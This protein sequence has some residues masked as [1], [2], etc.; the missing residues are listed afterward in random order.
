MLEQITPVVLTFNEGPNIGR[1]LE[2][3]AWAH[4][5]VVLD[6]HST[7]NT[8]EIVNGFDNAQAY[9]RRFDN[10]ATQWQFALE[11]TG[12]DTDWVLCMD[13]DWVMGTALE[14]EIAALGPDENLCGYAIPFRYLVYGEPLR[15]SLYPPVTALFRR[16]HGR[17]VQ[18][19]HTQRVQVDGG[20]NPLSSTL[21]HDDRKSLSRWLWAQGNYARLEA[22]AQAGTAFNNLSLRGRLRR[23][24][25]VMPILMPCHFLLMRGGLLDGRTGVFYALQRMIFEALLALEIV[26]Q[27]WSQASEDPRRDQRIE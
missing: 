6:S 18:D 16:A 5:V 15:V 26:G 24:L 21:D 17:F 25:I 2:R 4:R 23:M 19:G 12:I 9:E 22:K 20:V 14:A 10:H 8:V 7:D 27:R 1:T 3:L 13:A 11:Q